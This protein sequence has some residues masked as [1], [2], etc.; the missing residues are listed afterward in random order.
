MLKELV[1]LSK[2]NKNEVQASK[3]SLTSYKTFGCGPLIIDENVYK[4]IEV[5]NPIWFQIISTHL[6]TFE[7]K[8]RRNIREGNVG[9]A[10]YCQPETDALL[11]EISPLFF[12]DHGRLVT[13]VREYSFD[14]EFNTFTSSCKLDHAVMLGEESTARADGIPMSGIECKNLDWNFE[15]TN[16]WQPKAQ[17]LLYLCGLADNFSLQM[18][19][20]SPPLMYLLLQSGCQWLLLRRQLCDTPGP[21]FGRY[22][23]TSTPPVSLLSKDSLVTSPED[24]RIIVCW[25]IMC[26]M[27]AKV[28]VDDI[29]GNRQVELLVKSFSGARLGEKDNEERSASSA[30]AGGSKIGGGKGKKNT[31]GTS[32]GSN[33]NSRS[34]TADENSNNSAWNIKHGLLTITE[35]NMSRG[36]RGVVRH[37]WDNVD[38]VSIDS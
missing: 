13:C 6:T 33:M 32:K 22:L 1:M 37:V 15:S 36:L 5:D 19:G 2:K 35:R 25:L 24:H 20:R 9:E 4:E 21:C 7:E 14:V 26:C 27:Q 38:S 18:Q 16:L 11:Q 31:N 10:L 3:L 12:G 30:T 17:A 28:L 8:I 23:F 34:M 29:R